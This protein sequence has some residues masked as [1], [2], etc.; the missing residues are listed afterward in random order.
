M[1]KGEKMDS[2]I[3]LD[4]IVY[5]SSKKEMI[6]CNYAPL[7]IV[8]TLNQGYVVKATDKIEKDTFICE[9]HLVKEGYNTLNIKYAEYQKLIQE[10]Q[11]SSN[12][13]QVAIL[14]WP[15]NSPVNYLL[16]LGFK[17]N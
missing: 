1:F 7:E 13:E 15:T 4:R 3:S 2:L 16:I 12:K 11:K 10:R 5:F 6:Y 8:L 9:Y 14:N 17:S